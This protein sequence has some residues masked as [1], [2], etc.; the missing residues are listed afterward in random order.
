MPN[1]DFLRAFVEAA[2][3]TSSGP[4]TEISL[5]EIVEDLGGNLESLQ[6]FLSDFAE[7]LA[8]EDRGIRLEKVAGGWRFVTRPDLD[9]VL[10]RFHGLSSRQKLSQAALEVLSIVAY[11]QPVTLPEINFIRASNSTSVMK[12]LLDRGLLRIAG[13]KKVVGKPFLYRST[14]EF[15]VHFGLESLNELPNPE[16]LVRV[17]S[18]QL[19]GSD[20]NEA[21]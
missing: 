12:T 18:P 11:R 3:L 6:S 8:Q 17:P 10:R 19:S 16:E 14:R 7:V 2:L 5:L 15:L 20:L 13:R 21:H 4:V 9:E 1:E